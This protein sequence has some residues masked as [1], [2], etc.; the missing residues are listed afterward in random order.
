MAL[1]IISFDVNEKYTHRHVF[2]QLVKVLH[3]QELM[4]IFRNKKK[5]KRM[6]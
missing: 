6:A 2:K 1:F 3:F 5:K 4:L